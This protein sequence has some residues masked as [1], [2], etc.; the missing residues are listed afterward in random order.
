M[1]DMAEF[2]P[3]TALQRLGGEE[4]I[5]AWVDRFYDAVSRDPLLAPLFPADLGP[6]RQKQFEF[7]VQML[8]GPALYTERHG[9]PFLRY[10]HRHI[11]IGQAE[12]DAWMSCL[13]ASLHEVTRDEELIAFLE[14]RIAPIADHMVNHRPDQKDARFFR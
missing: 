2:D 3:S 6:S 4:G 13:M 14:R 8:G 7:F 1:A 11:T 9:Q 12:R 5:R 10:R